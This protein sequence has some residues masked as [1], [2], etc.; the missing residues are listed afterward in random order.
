MLVLL[1][2]I[3]CSWEESVSCTGT[4]GSWTG[5]RGDRGVGYARLDRWGGGWVKEVAGKVEVGKLQVDNQLLT[6]RNPVVL[7]RTL[8][9][10]AEA[11]FLEQGK[12]LANQASLAGMLSAD[13]KE[14]EKAF[15]SVEF[16]RLL[17]HPS[18][19]YY[20][21]F[22]FQLQ[23]FD[24]VLEEDFV[25][26][27]V[28]YLQ[29]LPMD[30]L[31]QEK[32]KRGGEEEEEKKG[33]EDLVEDMTGAPITR[34]YLVSGELTFK[35]EQMLEPLVNRSSWVAGNQG[36]R[37]YFER[38][39]VQPMRINVTLVMNPI[40]GDA[41]PPSGSSSEW[42]LRT[43]ASSAGFPLISL[44]RAP[45][46]LNSL[47]LDN[48]FQN[49]STLQT[50]VLRHYGVQLLQ[51]LHKILGSVELLGAPLSLVDN[52]ATGVMDFFVEPASATTPE[53]FLSGAMKGTVS[54]M[55]HSSYGVLHS[56]SSLA[57]G[58]GTG[59]AKLTFDDSYIQRELGKPK[60]E[61][62]K[63]LYSSNPK[64][65][66]QSLFP[67]SHRQPLFQ[68]HPFR[69][70]QR[71]EGTS[72]QVL[73]GA[74]DLGLGFVGAVTGL[75]LPPQSFP[76][77]TTQY[78]PSP[79]L[80]P[81]PSPP[82]TPFRFSQRPEGTS[83]QVLR[84]A[85]DLGLGFVGAV[86]GLVLQP[87]EGARREGAVGAVKGMGI[88]VV[89]LVT[90]PLSGLLGFASTLTESA[91]TGI[92]AI[93]GDV[94]RR[95]VP[96]IRLPSTFGRNDAI[97]LEPEDSVELKLVLAILDFGRYRDEHLL[98]H[99]QTS[100]RKAVLFTVVRLIFY[101]CQR[102][103]FYWQIPLK[104]MGMEGRLESIILYEAD[105]VIARKKLPLR[106][107]AR[108]VIKTT[109][110]ELHMALLVKLNRHLAR[111]RA[112]LPSS[113]SPSTPRHASHEPVAAGAAADGSLSSSRPP[114]ATSSPA[115][116]PSH[117][118]PSP[119]RLAQ[120][121]GNVSELSAGGGKAAGK[122]GKAAAASVRRSS[123]GGG[124]SDHVAGRA[125]AG[126]QFP[127]TKSL[128]AQNGQEEGEK[129]EEG[130]SE[131][132]RVMG[133]AGVAAATGATRWRKHAHGRGAVGAAADKGKSPVD[134]THSGPAPVR[135]KKS[136]FRRGKSGGLGGGD[137]LGKHGGVIWED[138]DMEAAHADQDDSDE[139]DYREDGDGVA[140]RVAQL[141]REERQEV[142]RN[143]DA[144]L[145]TCQVASASAGGRSDP[146]SAL[147]SVKFLALAAYSRV[148]SHRAHQATLGVTASRGVRRGD[149]SQWEEDVSALLRTMVALTEGAIVIAFCGAMTACA[150]LSRVAIRGTT[151][152]PSVACCPRRQQ[153]QSLS[154]WK[155]NDH[156]LLSVACEGRCCRFQHTS[157]GVLGSSRRQ[158][159]GA[160]RCS[161]ASADDPR[162]TIPSV[163]TVSGD[164]GSLKSTSQAGAQRAAR[165]ESDDDDVLI[166][167][168]DV[169]KSFGSKHILRGASLKIR[170][171]EAVGVIGPSGTGKSTILKIM[172]GLLAPDKG[173][174]WICGKK[175]EGLI[176]DQENVGL[177][178][179]LVFQSAA[180][181][182]SLTVR[183]NVGFLLYEHSRLSEEEI[184]LRVKDSLKAVGLKNVEERFPSEL[185]GGMK[186][187][188]ALARAIVSDSDAPQLEEEVV[189]YDEPTAGLDP[190]A[191]TVVEDL[192][193][194]LH[195]G[196][197]V[198][199]PV[200][201]EIA[202]GLESDFETESEDSED[203]E[204]GGR[205]AGDAASGSSR[206]GSGSGGGSKA[207]RMAS[208]SSYIVVTHQHSTIRRAVDRLLF[209]YG[210]EVVWE[211]PTEEF[212]TTDNPIVR[213]FA[214]GSL[215]GPIR[216]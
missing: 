115:V 155:H 206:D 17:Q 110:R 4:E 91:G 107:P 207:S 44:T 192:I 124:G 191:S 179:G 68:K 106:V 164:N 7:S 31:W 81:R 79:Y 54:L 148:Q 60:G 93:G 55:K 134:Q 61:A 51:G 12:E 20:R 90:K 201:A 21:R 48:A 216:Y 1:E 190:I 132:A 2:D 121:P 39:Q 141:D 127:L 174:V 14:K 119:L 42:H 47:V 146:A 29:Q 82:N 186:K 194:S 214:V 23:E 75:V 128:P 101:D 211:G 200:T 53:E 59:F 76:V 159:S 92:R 118:L 46:R 130:D 97:A 16:T 65:S 69:F 56:I 196:S 67:L 117:S 74:Q 13:P 73:R 102:N 197:S 143:L 66:P 96:R 24:L 78:S 161:A 9:F 19:I 95:T 22:L 167:L 33:D 99:L 129:D 185:S 204:G 122:L 112:T 116:S 165:E 168:K 213:Q 156:A 72:Q 135:A 64:P 198:P 70:S 43:T 183:E 180:L 50:Y 35:S 45:L 145:T 178:I 147:V 28:A 199:V 86:T 25:D 189:M 184:R 11:L 30:D 158:R 208:V 154:L 181:F 104:V 193:R 113:S 34:T 40:K 15:V 209:L 195:V 172:A 139:D 137:K 32:D 142:R 89:G 63:Y 83:Q 131:S 210:G 6:A 171:G 3:C 18:I 80:H 152:L 187:R 162:A 114:S 88:G 157:V 5:E 100:G 27:V 108:K 138:V 10:P 26:T 38:F 123:S 136:S 98:D 173:E 144:I 177:R 49:Q 84:G 41:P 94:T 109:T 170:R 182:D 85:Q 87:L 205:G 140:A 166:E 212:D 160:V 163:A 125:L 57:G 58:I 37:W 153:Q 188:V 36:L 77:V 133:V 202:A 150:C 149:D 62:H 111:I 175:R 203:E 8:A 105:V 176:S 126:N 52:L 215:D 103:V 169:Y 71:P 151:Q 120:S